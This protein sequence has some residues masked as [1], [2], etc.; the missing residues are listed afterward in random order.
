VLALTTPAI[1]LAYLLWFTLLAEG[2]ERW[3]CV[4]AVAGAA[5]SVAASAVL[6]AVSPDAAAA[7]WG[8]GAGAVLLLLVL[9]ARFV[10]TRAD[11]HDGAR[12]D[13]SG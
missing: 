11:R 10:L 9:T 13:R 2:Q 6:L 7:A 5:T 8:T 1:L 4:G 3:L 12:D